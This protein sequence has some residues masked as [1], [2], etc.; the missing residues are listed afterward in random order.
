MNKAILVFWAD[1]FRSIGVTTIYSS[2][3]EIPCTFWSVLIHVWHAA[4]YSSAVSVTLLMFSI[5]LKFQYQD[6]TRS[7]L[8]PGLQGFFQNLCTSAL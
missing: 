7:E 5:N 6:G 2:S 3:N 8:Y 4:V 1:F